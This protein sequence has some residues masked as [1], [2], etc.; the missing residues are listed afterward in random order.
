M[1]RPAQIDIVVG[2]T[3]RVVLAGTVILVRH[4]DVLSQVERAIKA[5]AKPDGPAA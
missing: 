2:G 4:D 1:D 3:V 5:A